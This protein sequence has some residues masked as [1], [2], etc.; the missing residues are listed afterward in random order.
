M[1]S[2]ES[3]GAKSPSG[4]AA[5]TDGSSGTLEPR[6]DCMNSFMRF[7]QSPGT[8]QGQY[9]T[10]GDTHRVNAVT[11]GKSN[12]SAASNIHLMAYLY[13]YPSGTGAHCYST[14]FYQKVTVAVSSSTAL[15]LVPLGILE[16][17]FQLHHENVKVCV[18]CQA[19]STFKQSQAA[20][21]SFRV[22]HHIQELGGLTCSRRARLT[23]KY[24]WV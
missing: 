7:Q 11:L 17:T 22:V 15:H 2:M 24:K 6:K 12:V 16:V 23:V 8:T 9:S 14:D 13:W 19:G 21:G 1:V 10:F 20:Q 5:K 18:S 3:A 4:L